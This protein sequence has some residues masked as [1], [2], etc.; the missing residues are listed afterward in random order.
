MELTKDSLKE[1]YEKRIKV[2]ETQ[3]AQFMAN[4]NAAEGA[5][6]VVRDLLSELDHEEPEVKDLVDKCEGGE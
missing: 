6:M 2:L 3:K 5:L 4:V 1:S